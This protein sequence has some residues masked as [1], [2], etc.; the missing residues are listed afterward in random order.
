M[1]VKVLN[2]LDK[3]AN[4]H[5]KNPAMGAHTV[6]QMQIKIIFKTS[7]TR[8]ITIVKIGAALIMNA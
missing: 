3:A 8:L 6:S 1:S 7:Q 5:M 2:P 4:K